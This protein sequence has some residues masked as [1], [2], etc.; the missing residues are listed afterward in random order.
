MDSF[1]S[2]TGVGMMANLIDERQLPAM[3][4]VWPIERLP[5]VPQAALPKGYVCQTCLEPDRQAVLTLVASEWPGEEEREHV[6]DDDVLPSGTFLMIHAETGEP[7]ATA[8]A[9]RLKGGQDDFPLVGTICDVVVNPLHRGKGLGRMVTALALDGLIEA[10]YRHIFLR[11]DGWRLPAIRCYLQL[12]FVPLLI[13]DDLL[14]R[15]RRI[16]DQIGW[17]LKEADWPRSLAWTPPGAFGEERALNKGVALFR[18]F[19]RSLVG[20]P[21]THFC[22]A[23]D[24]LWLDLDC[25]AGDD[26]TSSRIW[27]NPFWQVR[28][29][30]EM[31][32]GSDY[33]R[34]QGE[35]EVEAVERAVA[36]LRQLIGEPVT[37]LEVKPRSN[38]LAVEIGERFLVQTFLQDPTASDNWHISD[39]GR[40]VALYGSPRGLEVFRHHRGEMRPTSK[41]GRQ[42]G[43]LHALNE[44]GMVLCNPRDREAAHRAEMEGIATDDRDA[45]TCRRCL[46]LLYKRDKARHEGR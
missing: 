22:L 17:P 31:M 37:G 46:T 18:K 12:G 20:R 1:G 2:G 13:Q 35:R 38:A 19:R 21:V 36:W 27:L 33:S 40:R 26:N 6:F 25:H 42:Q 14:P 23:C 3:L 44:H 7:V 8:I 11:V 29:P 10:G 28:G 24:M 43:D 39:R 45:V 34:S 41:G 32:I 16:C 4:M 9:R 5:S 30:G 15:W